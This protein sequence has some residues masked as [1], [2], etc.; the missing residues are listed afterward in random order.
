MPLTANWDLVY[1]S[2]TDHDRL[3]EHYQ[4]LAE[5]ADDAL[6]ELGLRGWV[7]EE[8]NNSVNHTSTTTEIICASETVT[9][10]GTSARY[11]ALWMGT[12]VGSVT[13]DLARLRIRY[14]SGATLTTGGTQARINT[15]N[16]LV[17]NKG[18]PFV[19]GATITGLAAGQWTIG[20]TVQR[21]SGSGNNSVVGAATDE[22]YLLIL[23]VG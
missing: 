22:E 3:W 14:Q 4:N 16:P 7:T 9:S 19:C 23:R 12:F 13:S 10:P 8:V 5:S 21:A 18:Q 17:A 11:A 1:P 6:T 20:G 15:A 2:S